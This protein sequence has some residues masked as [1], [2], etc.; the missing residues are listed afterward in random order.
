MA[1]MSVTVGQVFRIGFCASRQFPSQWEIIGTFL[2]NS[3][4]HMLAGG[5]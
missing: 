2:E 5:H 4:A 1:V 3:P